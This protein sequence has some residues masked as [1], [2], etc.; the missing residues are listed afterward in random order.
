MKVTVNGVIDVMAIHYVDA[1]HV[2]ISFSHIFTTT[3]SSNSVISSDTSSSAVAEKPR[4]R[5]G[6]FG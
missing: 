1:E 5:M 6:Q 4:C 3:E 2:G